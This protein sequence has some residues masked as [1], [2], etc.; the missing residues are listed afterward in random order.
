L[1]DLLQL[2]DQAKKE[3]V[4]SKG[5]VVAVN[6][7]NTRK[8]K[9]ETESTASRSLDILLLLFRNNKI[10]IVELTFLVLQNPSVGFIQNAGKAFE[11]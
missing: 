1:D 8:K 6:R 2:R 11:E 3:V 5:A 10:I 4:R 9:R 7:V